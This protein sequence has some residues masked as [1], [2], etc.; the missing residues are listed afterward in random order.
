MA[1]VDVEK[2]LGVILAKDLK[3]GRQC[4]EAA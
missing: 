1:E 4:R 2:D 3:A